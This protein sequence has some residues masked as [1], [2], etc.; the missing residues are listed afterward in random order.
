MKAKTMKAKTETYY[1][2]SREKLNCHGDIVDSHFD[3]TL[4]KLSTYSTEGDLVLIRSFESDSEGVTDRSWAY[5]KDGKLPET[6]PN[7]IRVPKRFHAELAKTQIK[8]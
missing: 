1:E 7:G 4:A 2:W 8:P 3:D 5:V 6:F